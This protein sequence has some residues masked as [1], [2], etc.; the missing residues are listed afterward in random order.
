MT[1]CNMILPK[2][3][4]LKPA[5]RDSW[6]F[7]FVYSLLPV[8]VQRLLFIGSFS[9][10]LK[11]ITT[12]DDIV[13]CKM[14]ELLELSND[15]SGSVLK[16]PIYISKYVWSNFNEFDD[17]I[18]ALECLT[19]KDDIRLLVEKILSTL[20]DWFLYADRSYVEEEMIQLVETKF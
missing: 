3:K 15:K 8:R 11:H 18:E 6:F 4:L 19:D 13:I 10:V 17:D 12:N 5:I 14:N 9:G 7:A 1:T 16:Y 2:E 20:P